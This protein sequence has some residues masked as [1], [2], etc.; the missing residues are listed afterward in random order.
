[1]FTS[2][3]PP[4]DWLEEIVEKKRSE[5]IRDHQYSVYRNNAAASELIYWV[6]QENG[7]I[8]IRYQ[9]L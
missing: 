9:H 3:L 2:D 1:M 4:L 8:L 7:V 6:N 5:M